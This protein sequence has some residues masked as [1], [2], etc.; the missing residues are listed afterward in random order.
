MM[1]VLHNSATRIKNCEGNNFPQQFF[2][3]GSV[4]M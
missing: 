3:I 4:V 2:I 1:T